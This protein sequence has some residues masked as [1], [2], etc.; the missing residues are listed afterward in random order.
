MFGGDS[1]S[2]GFT[3]WQANSDGANKGANSK[4]K[5]PMK[6]F[7]VDGDGSLNKEEFTSFQDA[8]TKKMG[9][10]GLSNEHQVF[11]DLDKDKNGSIDHAELKAG[12]SHKM[13][14]NFHGQMPDIGMPPFLEISS[15]V[16]IEKRSISIEGVNTSLTKE[17]RRSFITQALGSGYGK[18]DMSGLGFVD[19]LDSLES[20]L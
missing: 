18:P 13:Q 5:G 7:D 10:K 19:L 8:V 14:N 1:F 4:E 9:S 15:S 11:D 3:K 17:E 6:R 20:E 16:S 2:G 12:R